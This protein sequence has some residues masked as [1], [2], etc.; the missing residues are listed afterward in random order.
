MVRGGLFW[1][2]GVVDNGQY[3]KIQRGR[4]GR[5][6]VGMVGVV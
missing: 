6:F 1:G 4:I 3:W 5:R 2:G